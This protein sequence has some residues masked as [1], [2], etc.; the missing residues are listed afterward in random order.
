[1]K[2]SAETRNKSSLSRPLMIFSVSGA[3]VTGFA[4]QHIIDFIGLSLSM[5]SDNKVLPN[6]RA[7]TTLVPLGIKSGLQITSNLYGCS[8]T[9]NWVIPPPTYFH[10]PVKA[11]IHVTALIVC[12]PP[13]CLSK[14][15]PILI[16][17]GWLFA[18]SFDNFFPISS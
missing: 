14:A 6:W 10:A 12:P 18:I 17:T 2:C 9:G 8:Q 16:P 13:W 5:F 3:W 15:T 1:M 7:F 4:F 11:G